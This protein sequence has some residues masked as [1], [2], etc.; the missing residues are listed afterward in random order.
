MLEGTHYGGRKK[1]LEGV[2]VEGEKNNIG[3]KR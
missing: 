1:K 3:G 2:M